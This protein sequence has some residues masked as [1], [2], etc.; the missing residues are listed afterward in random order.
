MAVK[1]ETVLAVAVVAA[2]AL[3][4]RPAKAKG[5]KKKPGK[6]EFVPQ[7]QEPELP[8]DG[9]GL[10]PWLSQEVDDAA[11]AVIE[12]GVTEL[13]AGLI[14]EEVAYIVYEVT[15]EGDYAQW[16]PVQGD[17]RGW[18]IWD[19]ILVRVNLIL[20][21]LADDAINGDDEPDDEPEPGEPG[22]VITGQ[23]VLPPYPEPGPVDVAAWENPDNYPTPGAFHQVYYQGGDKN[24]YP[25]GHPGRNSVTTMK[26]LAQ[27]ALYSFAYTVT[28]D[29]DKAKA[30]GDDPEL[31]RAYR[32]LIDCSPYNHALF[33]ARFEPPHKYDSP[34]GL[35]VAMIPAHDDVRFALSKGITPRR[36]VDVDNPQMAPNMSQPFPWLPPLDPEAFLQG[37][38]R[39]DP[40]YWDSGDSKIMPPPEVLAL[41]VGGVDPQRFW[42]CD[43]QASFGFPE[44]E[45]LQP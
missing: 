2:F 12:E 43:V 22:L 24:R 19:K 4:S 15:P 33:A 45:E 10:Y 29:L 23:E 44:D 18:C 38:I 13:E 35:Q 39:V 42:G 27:K 26:H 14:A 5:K 32:A 7:E 11:Y 9:C 3:S 40:E 25:E 16:P 36:L 17:S 31:W 30:A 8:P 37:E 6:A 41:G 21:E 20:A 34:H 28:G 1:P